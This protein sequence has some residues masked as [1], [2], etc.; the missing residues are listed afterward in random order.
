VE[1][2]SWVI[3]RAGGQK[4]GKET[5][6]GEGCYKK[7]VLVE[8]MRILNNGECERSCKELE[9]EKNVKGQRDGKKRKKQKVCRTKTQR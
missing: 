7:E 6:G 9:M 3:Y 5:W 4:G 8:G 2:E 1:H